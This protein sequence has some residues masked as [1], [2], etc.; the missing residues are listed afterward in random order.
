MGG[1]MDGGM[2]VDGWKDDGWEEGWVEGWMEGWVE[3]DPIHRRGK[4]TFFSFA[5]IC[6]EA[7]LFYCAVIHLHLS[8]GYLPCAG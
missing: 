8:L 4:E 2:V 3:G 5:C 6:R 7:S 1:G